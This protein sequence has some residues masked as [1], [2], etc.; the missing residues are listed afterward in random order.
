VRLCLRLTRRYGGGPEI[1]RRCI[2]ATSRYHSQPSV[3]LRKHKILVVWSRQPKKIVEKRFSAKS[4]TVKEFV[5]EMKKEMK[6]NEKNIRVYDFHNGRKLKI[7]TN[8]VCES[9]S[10]HALL[11]CRPRPWRRRTSWMANT[12]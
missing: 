2:A 7:L 4:C 12:C 11:T 1:S 9:S 8:W 5:T 10:L 6:F 3:E